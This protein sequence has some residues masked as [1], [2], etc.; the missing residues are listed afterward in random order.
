MSVVSAFL[1][2]G[3]PLPVLRP[4]N[5]PWAPLAAGMRE[6]GALLSDSRPDVV[7][8]YSTQWVAVLDQ[9]WQLRPHLEGVHVDETWHEYGEL[10]YAIDI[11]VPFSAACMERA[12]REGI[13]SRGVDYDGFPIDSGTLAAARSIDPEG[14]LR[15]AITA[16]NIY[17]DAER[18]RRLGAIVRSVAEE[19][20]TR[21]SVVAV[22]GLSGTLFRAPIDIEKDAIASDDDDRRNREILALLCRGDVKGLEEG[23][24]EYAREARV[25]MGFK[26]MAFLLGALDGRF[27]GARVLAYGP[28]YGSG[29][30]VVAFDR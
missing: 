25:D 23:F 9:L 24:E 7:V 4:D 13:R 10:P 20:E 18:T 22:G 11:D 8:V 12:G 2:P 14:R 29:S 27:Q 28:S 30:A 19:R 3:S 1:L 17:H 16:N 15:F 6:A 26:H 5:P 21:I